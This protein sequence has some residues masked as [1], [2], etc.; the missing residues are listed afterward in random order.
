MKLLVLSDIR[1]AAL[2]RD[3]S[4]YY[5]AADAI[6]TGNATVTECATGLCLPTGSKVSNIGAGNTS[7]AVTFHHVVAGTTETKV[8]ELDYINYDIAW[9]SSWKKPQ[10]SSTRNVTVSVN[11]GTPKRWALPIPGA[12]WF[13]TATL[14]LEVDGFRPG[15]N[16]VEFRAVDG[17]RGFAPESVGFALRE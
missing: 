3:I 15:N 5:V 14:A 1:Y 6:I 11:S 9:E 4:S 2:A 16:T 7:A 17:M 13:E 12:S 10:G 8:L